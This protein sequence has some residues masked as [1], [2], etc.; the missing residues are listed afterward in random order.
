MAD[1]LTPKESLALSGRCETIEDC[2]RYNDEIIAALKDGSI[3]A[4]QADVLSK[5]ALTTAEFIRLRERYGAEEFDRLFPYYE[6]EA[7]RVV[8]QEVIVSETT[9]GSSLSITCCPDRRWRG[10][11]IQERCWLG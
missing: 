8:R 11:A 4:E 2:Y 1:K 5:V 6:R 9:T 10:N 7:A 3:T